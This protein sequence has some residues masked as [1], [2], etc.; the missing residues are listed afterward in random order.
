M[1][2]EE[3]ERAIEGQ[4]ES[5]NLDF[6]A[7]IPWTPAS[8][9]KDFIA[10]ANVRDGGTIVIGVSEADD[11]FVGTGVCEE[12][13]K[14]YKIDAMR[15]KLYRYTDPS[16][17]FRLTFP[18]DLSGKKY[19]VIKVLPFKEI[20]IIS[21]VSI[22]DQMAAH[23][24]Y[25]RNT[26]R[27]VQSAPVSNSND[28]RDIIESAV[29][30]M[31]Q[32]RLDA[33]FNVGTLPVANAVVTSDENGASLELNQT[34]QKQL[35]EEIEFEP[36]GVLKRI[37]ECG[38]WKIQFIPIQPGHINTLKETLE[39]VKQSRTRLNWDFPH[40]PPNNN[41]NERVV[42]FESGYQM[43]S[44]LGSRKEFWRIYQSEQFLMYRA[45][46]ED[47]YAGDNFRSNL[48]DEYPPG[49]SL[50]LYT[51]LTFLITETFEY[52]SRLCQNGF[53]KGGVKVFLTLYNTKNRKL[54]IDASGRMPFAYDRVTGAEQI[55]ISKVL[56]IE[57]AIADSV[58]IG[59]DF[60]LKVLDKFAYNP[61]PEMISKYQKDW[62]SGTFQH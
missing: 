30:K 37:M 42:P 7:D 17:D 52:L 41:E 56:S 55:S 28:L 45:L 39:V 12:N 40:V 9:V 48:A 4:A 23:T 34:F 32:R 15:D 53:Y 36:D 19:V 2:T 44:D 3:L 46:V 25:Y 31:M 24:I 59:N 22:P 10:M 6:K 16:I 11:A 57:E 51:S 13:L 26:D 29:V 33:G 61:G 21:K 8:M 54:R 14:T 62:L 35:D 20:P 49:S 38:Y 5:Q 47:W 27:R 1:T 60:I 58:S 18:A 50:T 43:E